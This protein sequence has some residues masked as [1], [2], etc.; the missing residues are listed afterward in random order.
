MQQLGIRKAEMMHRT[1]APT[2]YLLLDT[3]L[4]ESISSSFAG[5]A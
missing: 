4:P 1:P 3:F 5:T 2:E